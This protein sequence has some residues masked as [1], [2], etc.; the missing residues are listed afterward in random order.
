MKELRV[1]AVVRDDA[2][3][4]VVR[5]ARR[6]LRFWTLPGGALNL[7]ESLPEAV[8]REVAEE[9]GY[10]VAVG[11]VVCVME[12]GMDRWSGRRL[13]ICFEAVVTGSQTARPKFTER[14]VE[15][16]WMTLDELRGNFLPS[17]LLVALSGRNYGEY[18]GNV[19][20]PDHPL[21]T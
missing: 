20:E 16:A 21:S 9:T 5:H 15:C 19:T 8:A 4:L 7:G 10:E 18:L 3:F 2:R 1:S 12:I 11:N 17:A 13:E 6:G 14:I